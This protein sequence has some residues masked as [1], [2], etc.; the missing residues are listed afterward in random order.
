MSIEQDCLH[1]LALAQMIGPSAAIEASE[2]H[3]QAQFVASETLPV[4]MSEEDVAAL[5]SF[6]V[7]FEGGKPT[8]ITGDPLFCRVSLP[9]GWGKRSTDHAMYN[10][11]IDDKGRKRATI[12]YKAAFYDR[13][14]FMNCDRR[15]SATTHYSE[16][17][18]AVV[19]VVA[20]S[21]K[22]I[23]RGEP[24]IEAKRYEASDKARKVAAAW[25]DEHFPK[26]Q[27]LTA[28]WD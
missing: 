2:A 25:L 22:E 28:Y 1:T 3:G 8:P 21:G 18:Q 19:P 15:Y 20:D 6:G 23:W 5:K 17:S 13:D 7:G 12:F 11:L 27:D 9:P 24:V 14:A 10:N 26:W 4:R 16:N